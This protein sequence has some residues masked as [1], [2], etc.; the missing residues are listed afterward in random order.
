MSRSDERSDRERQYGTPT[1]NPMDGAVAT[2][3]CTCLGT[4]KG[5]AGLGAGWHCVMHAEPGTPK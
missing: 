1:P 5:A 4:C 2:R 3:P